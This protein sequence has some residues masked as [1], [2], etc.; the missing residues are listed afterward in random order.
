[1]YSCVRIEEV[2]A[3]YH[4]T[5]NAVAGASLFRSEDDRI[6]FYGFLAEEAADSEWTVLEHCLMTT[7]YH[8]VFTLNKATLSSGFHRLQSRYAKWFNRCHERRGVLWQRRFASE[9]IE[10]EAH[11]REAL[12]YVALNPVRARICDRPEDYEWCS[13][14]SAIGDYWP[15]P[16]VDEEALLGLFAPDKAR[17][18]KLFRAFVEETDPRVR[19]RQTSRQTTVRR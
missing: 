9:L 11:L 3:T 6:R 18:R 12:R 4:V 5:A 17:G 1:M 8:L 16:L 7:H 15:D 2:G 19:R 14:G 13:Y 10:S